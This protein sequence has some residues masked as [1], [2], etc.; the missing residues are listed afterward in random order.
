[1]S[2]KTSAGMPTVGK[3]RDNRDVT[4]FPTDLDVGK[5]H[6]EPKQDGETTQGGELLS[7]HKEMIDYDS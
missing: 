4:H 5:V 7:S 6:S 2:P 1:M 3:Y